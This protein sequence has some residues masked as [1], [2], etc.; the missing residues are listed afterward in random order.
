MAV[1]HWFFVVGGMFA[2]AFFGT[3]AVRSEAG[4]AT[5]TAHSHDF[6][7]VFD[8]T[9]SPVSNHPTFAYVD[10]G[11]VDTRGAHSRAW[12]AATITGGVLRKST[13]GEGWYFNGASPKHQNWFASAGTGQYYLTA[14]AG[15]VTVPLQVRILESGSAGIRDFALPSETP[16]PVGEYPS[17]GFFAENHFDVY[18]NI[19]SSTAIGPTGDLNLDGITNNLD[20]SLLQSR[21]GQ[22]GG[23]LLGD[24]NNDLVIDNADLGIVNQ[25][26]GSTGITTRQLLNGDARVGGPESGFPQL[27][28][29]GDLENRFVATQ[30]ASPNPGQTRIGAF[31]PEPIISTIIS[32]PVNVP[33]TLNLDQF[34][35]YNLL[36][37]NAPD[38]DPNQVAAGLVASVSGSLVSEVLLPQVPGEDLFTIRAVIDGVPGDTNF[39]GTVDLKDLNMVRNNFGGRSPNDLGD[40]NGDGRIDLQDLN[41]VRNNFGRGGVPAPEPSSWLLACFAIPAFIAARRG[42]FT[43]C[44]R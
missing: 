23:G 6:S 38:A 9:V 19:E 44:V 31:A 15:V 43:R 41:A 24:L 20:V 28:A 8:L 35:T 16:A 27:T 12:A 40:T 14:P 22:T 26:L 10:T 13:G 5:A 21:L 1:R 2:A 33:F 4:T 34:M 42:G 32:L 39:D 25:N 18:F 37:P 7:P 36:D 11:S 30:Q 29:T 17:Q 3:F